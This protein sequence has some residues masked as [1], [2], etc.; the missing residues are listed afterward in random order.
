MENKELKTRLKEKE[1]HCQQK[2]KEIHLLRNDLKE[3]SEQLKVLRE[4]VTELKKSK[5]KVMSPTG[6]VLSR[7]ERRVSRTLRAIEKGEDTSLADDSE[8][9]EID[10][11][12]ALDW[13]ITEDNREFKQPFPVDSIGPSRITKQ[14]TDGRSPC[15]GYLKQ[16]KKEEELVQIALEETLEDIRDTRNRIKKYGCIQQ[17]REEDKD[18]ETPKPQRPP[19]VTESGK[20][21]GIRKDIKVLENI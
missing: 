15:S 13:S 2:E 14:N 12:P 6:S 7:S 9:M 17:A 4:E 1:R 20:L 19:R 21:Q 5:G 11:L 3:I 8:A 18:M 16:K 10:H